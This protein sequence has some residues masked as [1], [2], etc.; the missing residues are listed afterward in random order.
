MHWGFMNAQ[1]MERIKKMVQFVFG[2]KWEATE[3]RL[4]VQSTRLQKGLN[5][6]T[7]TS[8]TVASRWLEFEW[9]ICSVHLTSQSIWYVDMYQDTTIK[10]GSNSR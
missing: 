7:E 4:K 8:V 1:N 9:G 6:T 2:R 5:N 3:A 10:Y